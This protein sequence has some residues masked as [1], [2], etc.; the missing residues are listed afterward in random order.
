MNYSDF[1]ISDDVIS[2]VDANRKIEAIRILRE[3]TGLGLK[4]A[5]D[6]V[7]RLARSR[8]GEP[9]RTA[10]MPEEGGASGMIRMV[11]LIAIILVIYFYFFAA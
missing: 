6:T 5:K 2:A 10:A 4:E 7:D 11:V 3:E 1:N 9:G 8:K